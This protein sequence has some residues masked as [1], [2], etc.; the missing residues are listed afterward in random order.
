MERTAARVL[1]VVVLLAATLG[2]TGAAEA[3][4]GS[5]TKSAKDKA[6]KA[7]GQQPAE[8]AAKGQDV[9]FDEN[10]RELTGSFLDSLI[11][12]R[13]AADKP[14]Q[15]RPELAARQAAITKEFDELSAKNGEAIQANSD[16][17]NQVESCWS[18]ALGE[19]QRQRQQAE[20]QRLLAN[21]ASGE[22]LA[23]LNLAMSQAQA[24]GD[25]ATFNRLMKQ[26]EA[27]YSPTHADSLAVRKQCGPIPAIHPAKVRMDAI[28]QELSEIAHKIRDMEEKAGK[29]Q[30]TECN[31]TPEQLGVAWDRIALY[32]AAVKNHQTP[33]G[34]TP[35]ELAALSERKD[36]LE[37]LVG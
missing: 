6:A 29:L 23:K 5:L 36:V 21:P 2:L 3:G 34:F 8:P 24:A 27:M 30:L 37:A 9:K 4:L 20:M 13:K 32:V 18:T 12:C 7:T 25:T 22:K 35:A 26:I 19:I 33:F 1:S 10:T 15:G 28:N 16:K 11:A 14:L 31:L 17:R